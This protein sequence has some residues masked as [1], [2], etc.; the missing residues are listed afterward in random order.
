MNNGGHS[1]SLPSRVHSWT[2]PVI[3][4]YARVKVVSPV[5]VS[6]YS[7]ASGLGNWLPVHVRSTSAPRLKIQRPSAG[8]RASAVEVGPVVGSACVSPWLSLPAQPKA[9]TPASTAVEGW[10]A[11]LRGRTNNLIMA[12]IRG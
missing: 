3:G 1:N 5:F 2:G 9:R 7:A 6:V 10:H 11:G 8:S 12:T 4:G